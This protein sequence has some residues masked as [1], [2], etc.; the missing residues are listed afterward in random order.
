VARTPGTIADQGTFISPDDADELVDLL[1][2]AAAVIGCLAGTP[3]AETALADGRCGPAV[4]CAEL[5]IDLRLAAA[6]LDE[7]TTAPGSKPENGM[8]PGK[9]RAPGKAPR[10]APERQ[11]SENQS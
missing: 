8:R 10:H 11:H 5:V 1:A 2:D 6:R 3:A 7:D 9:G 4:S